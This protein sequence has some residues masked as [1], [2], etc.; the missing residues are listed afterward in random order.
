MEREYKKYKFKIEEITDKKILEAYQSIEIYI[1][2]V[3][4]EIL[5]LTLNG[6]GTFSLYLQDRFFN[7]NIDDETKRVASFDGE[8]KIDEIDIVKLKLPDNIK[9]AVLKLNTTDE[10]SQG[11]GSYIEFKTDRIAYDN[12]KKILQI[13]E[14]NDK[15]VTYKFFHNAYTQLK[16]GK[17]SGIMFT[18]LEM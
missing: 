9:R 7:F 11:T 8:M 10:L 18:D 12:V 6:G 13:G 14:I 5:L 15:N 2:K 4:D 1:K 16:D 3:D 17:L